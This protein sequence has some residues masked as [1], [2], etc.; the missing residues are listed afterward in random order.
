M[1]TRIWIFLKDKSV[2][3]EWRMSYSV[4]NHPSPFLSVELNPALWPFSTHTHTHTQHVWGI[5]LSAQQSTHSGSQI[6]RN[7]Q[8]D[9]C[10]PNKRREGEEEPRGVTELCCSL[11]MRQGGWA[12]CCASQAPGSGFFFLYDMMFT[13]DCNEITPPI[14][15][16]SLGSRSV[17]ERFHKATDNLSCS[18]CFH[19]RSNVQG[20]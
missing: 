14:M 1:W 10:R 12:D 7:T 13:L 18:R 16:C 3:V 17:W 8:W 20:K 6:P 11:L 5:K 2:T 9:T 15:L 19:A 4:R